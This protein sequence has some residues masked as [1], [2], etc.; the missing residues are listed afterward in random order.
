[1]ANKI[2][3]VISAQDKASAELKKTEAGLKAFSQGADESSRASRALGVATDVAKVGLLATGAAAVAAGKFAVTAAAG[4]EQSLNIFRSVSGATAEQMVAV[5]ARSRELGKDLSL[6]GVSAAD[7]ALAMVELAKAGLSVN[8]TMAASKGVLSLAKAGQMETAQAAEIAAN[9]LNAFGLRGS[10]ASRVADILAAAAN[11][12]SADVTDLALSLQMSSAGA[13]AVKVPID[14]LVASIGLMANNGI[15]GSDAGTS[16]KTM[17]M[18]LIPQTDKQIASFRKL[19]LDF[20]NA[21]GNFV[22]MREMIRQLEVGTRNLTDEQKA[23]H[24]ETIFGSD[25]SRAANILLKEG[26]KGYDEM[27]RAVNKNGAATALAAA[28]NAGFKGALDGLKSTIETIAIDV[29]MKM[30]PG[31]TA[32][33]TSINSQ[34]EPSFNRL[35]AGGKAVWG[36]VTTIADE[37]AFRLGPKFEFLWTIVSTNLI[38]AFAQLYT[39]VLPLLPVIGGTLLVAVGLLA[40]GVNLVTF[41]FSGLVA[42]A[43]VLLQGLSDGNPIVWTLAGAFTGL[44]VAMG[45]HAI[46][47]TVTAAMAVMSAVTIPAL[48]AKVAAL[49]LMVMTPMVMPAIAIGAAL[50]AIAAVWNAYNEMMSAI[51][52]AKAS[53]A[54]SNKAGADLRA[55]ADASFKSGKIDQKEKDRLY[56]VSFKALGTNYA[57]GGATVVGEHGPEIVNMPRGAQVTQAYRSRNEL[58]Q[59]SG[60]GVTVHITGPVSFTDNAAIDYF[61]QRLNQSARLA[62]SGMSSTVGA[63]A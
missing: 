9:A 7:A 63:A 40:D 30:L 10:E 32:L 25:S 4:Y 11:A 59:G 14:N 27:T 38:P 42:L 33:A 55:T 23:Q 15:K 47:N 48:I 60:G 29:G 28:Q 58:G 53:Q 1:V 21:K 5:G 49:N 52:G 3:I 36:V 43:A 2:N 46:I 61:A 13:A 16:L 44:G 17:F 12:S 31:L 34:I 35:V 57:E 26:V 50:A 62:R 24:I 19:N 54:R 37:V 18:N 51:E 20:Y 8:D 22:G 45:I 39:A 6:P 56:S 41:A